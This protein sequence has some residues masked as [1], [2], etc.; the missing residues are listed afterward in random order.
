MK[1]VAEPKTLAE[2]RDYLYEIVRLQL[3][4]MHDWLTRHPEEKPVDVLRNRIDIYRKTDAN[5]DALNPAVLKWET[6]A[7]QA[8]EQPLLQCH[9]RHAADIAAFEVMGFDI[10]KPSLDARCERDF[11][12]D[13][14]LKAYQCGSLRYNVHAEP[15]AR[16]G[17]HIAN[18]VRPRSIFD[19]PHYLPA[20]FLT[21]MEQVE[22]LYGA[23]EILTGTW[24]NSSSRWLTLF[25]QEWQDNL[26]PPNRNVAWHYGF[27]GQFITARGTFNRKFGEHLRRTGEFYYQPRASHCSIGAMRSHLLARLGQR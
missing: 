24:L 3:F 12:D 22:A 14:A 1:N 7:W 13:S 4:F 5:P 23:T 2:H 11:L 16:V 17:F 20:C 9:A 10:L 21:L 18:A 15:T 19:N 6:D 8:I 26:Q 27:W 25:P